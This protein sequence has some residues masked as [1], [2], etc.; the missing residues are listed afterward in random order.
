[1]VVDEITKLGKEMKDSGFT[2]GDCMKDWYTTALLEDGAKFYTWKEIENAKKSQAGPMDTTDAKSSEEAKHPSSMKGTDVDHRHNLA[3][4]L[5]KVDLVDDPSGGNLASVPEEYPSSGTAYDAFWRTLIANRDG[6]G[7]PPPP[8]V[9]KT[10]FAPWFRA[11]LGGFTEFMTAKFKEHSAHGPR[12]IDAFN[13]WVNRAS[14]GSRI[15]RTNSGYIGTAPT[16][17]MPGDVVC[18]LYGGQTPFIL[19]RKAERYQFIGEC[20]VHGIME[21]EALDLGL[22]EV[23]FALR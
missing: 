11:C 2:Y 6:A 21:G 14:V 23:T 16:Y 5:T 15:F 3:I 12:P 4:L 10:H 22:D 19:R 13:E 1:M 8:S 7:N 20:Y 9:G 17:A 18:V